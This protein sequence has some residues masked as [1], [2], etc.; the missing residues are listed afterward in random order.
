[1]A[2]D[3]TA[4]DRP[5]PG[6]PSLDWLSFNAVLFDLDGVLTP[7]ALVH[8]AAWR[9]TFDE[10]LPRI[11]AQGADRGPFT[12]LDY[13]RFVDGRPRYEGVA[14]FLES[15]NISLPWG[16]PEDP[17]GVDTISAIGNKKNEMVSRI[18]DTT[19]IEPY[20]G[21]LALLDFLA[22]TDI[23]LAVVSSSANAAAVLDSAGI[24]DRFPVRVDGVVS[25]EMGLAGK[26]AP[27]TFLEAA[28]RLDVAPEQA[29]VVEDA[30]AGVA[31]GVAGGFGA[32]VGV[33]RVGEPAALI[34]AGAT[35]VVTDLEELI[36]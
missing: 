24:S 10:S 12:D 29:V 8:A 21:S 14:S 11:G 23:S 20:P 34:K 32:V 27:D 36:P 19:R 33:D 9:E 30:E 31:A 18:L 13:R 28:R 26:P 17:P 35:I 4:T 22:P 16:D 5:H 7:T 6:P 3:S 25:S 15:R 1:M 2:S